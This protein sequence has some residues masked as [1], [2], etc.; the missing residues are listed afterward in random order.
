[1]FS[2]WHLRGAAALLTLI[3]AAGASTAQQPTARQPAETG[4]ITA[5]L[6][7]VGGRLVD[8]YGGLPLE[9]A[10]VLVDGASIVAVGQVGQLAVPE[11]AKV[12]SAEGMT[13]LPGLW[14]SHGHLEHV[15]EAVPSLFAEKYRDRIPE[16][17]ANVARVS[18]L[19][20]ITSFRD[21]GGPL[22]EQQA[23]RADIEAGRKVGP[24]LFL[25]GPI[26][27]QRTRSQAATS[28]DFS[29]ATPEEARAAAERLIAM[30][31][32]QIKVYGFWDLP[33]LWE[34][35]AAAHQAGIG[36][37]ADVRHIEAY[38]TAVRAGVDRLHHVFTAESPADHSDEDLRLLVRGE[39][40]VG[41][42]PSANILR[43]PYILPTIEM[44][45]AYARALEFP[46]AV[47]HPRLR[48]VVP[49]DLY[50]VLRS[51]ERCRSAS[52]PISWW[53]TAIRCRTSRCCSTRSRTSS[54]T[55]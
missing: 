18:L 51:T 32:D 16:I 34:V 11:G 9:N 54:R 6:A 38:R 28:G 45:N 4:A 7:I 2:I 23:L 8:G 55:G 36:V 43:G 53:S 30:K 26:L 50:Q 41:T 17:M 12:L 1:M 31:V 44:R 3:A 39:K 5:T 47:D 10:V 22:A 20:G 40:P 48:Q 29:V 49:D 46:E 15:G 33:V 25:A 37:D 19:A 13:V 14:E 24:R 27:N 42:G 52:W 21:T 35:T